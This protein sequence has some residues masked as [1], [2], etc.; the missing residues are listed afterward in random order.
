MDPSCRRFGFDLLVLMRVEILAP[1]SLLSWLPSKMDNSSKASEKM[2]KIVA[3]CIGRS[4][5][6]HLGGQQRL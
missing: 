6:Y 3:P 2:N 4:T 5:P 1:F